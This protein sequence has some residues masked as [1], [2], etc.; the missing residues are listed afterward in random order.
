MKVK[1]VKK[2]HRDPG[3]TEILMI[4]YVKALL[5]DHKKRK[6]NNIKVLLYILFQTFDI[7]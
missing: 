3:K 2:L 6:F 4:I 1:G 7:G 5:I